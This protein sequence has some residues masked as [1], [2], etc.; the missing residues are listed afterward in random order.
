MA[1]QLVAYIMAITQSLNEF[2]DAAAV[3]IGFQ[4]QTMRLLENE[5]IAR[6]N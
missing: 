2:S 3:N 4:Y 5:Q 1:K 6:M